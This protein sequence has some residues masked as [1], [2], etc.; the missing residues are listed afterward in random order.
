MFLLSL[1]M[2]ILKFRFCLLLSFS[3]GTQDVAFC[4]MKFLC[5]RGTLC[6]KFRK[7]WCIFYSTTCTWNLFE[8]ILKAIEL[9]VD[10]CVSNANIC[11]SSFI[12]KPYYVDCANWIL[13]VRFSRPCRYGGL[14]SKFDHKLFLL[15]NFSFL[16]TCIKAIS[17]AIGF[18]YER[19][20]RTYSF[21]AR[22]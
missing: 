16:V 22:L 3:N 9:A 20:F 17:L 14:F 21:V 18:A 6:A 13:M 15:H 8:V 7:I 2:L 11:Q 1:E 19:I 10:L 12:F 5:N 4:R